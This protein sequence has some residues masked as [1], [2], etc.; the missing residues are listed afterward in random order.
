MLD[1]GTIV[2]WNYHAGTEYYSK[3]GEVVFYVPKYEDVSLLAV[4]EGITLGRVSFKI[5]SSIDRYLIKVV[6]NGGFVF[7]AP[8]ATG[9]TVVGGDTEPV[10]DDLIIMKTDGSSSF[11]DTLSSGFR[12]S[13]IAIKPDAKVYA[14]VTQSLL[15]FMV[16]GSGAEYL[17]FVRRSFR[18]NAY[19]FSIDKL[20]ID[21]YESQPSNLSDPL[22]T[23]VGTLV[24][25]YFTSLGFETSLATI[26][27]VLRGDITDI[28]PNSVIK[29]SFKS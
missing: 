25:E 6:E 21:D 26:N 7:Y 8:K 27:N 14:R 12:Y 23:K 1:T 28:T 29:L 15:K 3:T 11:G 16:V 22:I 17:P 4:K 10:P 18:H 2:T 19:T 20:L 9:V 24:F 5:L 13:L